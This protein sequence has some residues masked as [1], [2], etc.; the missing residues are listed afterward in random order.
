M[1]HVE[2][3]RFHPDQPQVQLGEPEDH[4]PGLILP[5]GEINWNCPCLG[6]MAIGLLYILKRQQKNLLTISSGPCGIEFR[7]AFSCFHYSQEEPKGKECLPKFA[8]MQECM[9]QY[10]ELYEEKKADKEEA[11]EAETPKEAGEAETI[12][13]EA[14]E[15]EKPKEGGAEDKETEGAAATEAGTKDE[16]VAK[17]EAETSYGK[18]EEAN[19]EDPSEPAVSAEEVKS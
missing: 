11:G 12:K 14:G 5:N 17:P 8:D 10:P 3:H 9:K 16:E 19:K 18:A 15:D 2:A 6:G 7:E 13:E 4:P 1:V